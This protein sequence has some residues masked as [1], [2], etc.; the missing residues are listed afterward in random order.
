MNEFKIKK[1]DS[2]TDSEKGYFKLEGIIEST[3]QDIFV[4]KAGAVTY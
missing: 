3:L 2:Y 4:Y 1:F